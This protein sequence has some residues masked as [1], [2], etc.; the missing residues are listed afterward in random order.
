M[1]FR[2][3][4]LPFMV[5][6]S[7][8]SVPFCVV[9][10]V[11]LCVFVSW[12]YMTAIPKFLKKFSRNIL[13]VLLRLLACSLSFNIWLC[14]II[15]VCFITCGSCVVCICGMHMC[16]CLC[17]WTFILTL[18]LYTCVFA[19]FFALSCSCKIAC[20]LVCLWDGKW[21]CA[22]LSIFLHV[23]VCRH[24]LC[25]FA[26]KCSCRW[27]CVFAPSMKFCVRLCVWVLPSI[28]LCCLACSNSN[29]CCRSEEW[30]EWEVG[31]GA[32]TSWP[33]PEKG[34]WMSVSI[35]GRQAAP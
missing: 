28:A 18:H 24:A 9:L 6:L 17:Q 8:L 19:G 15:V 2:T 35:S 33:P 13:V 5:N 26:C 30:V 31:G 22:S 29:T 11:V 34:S 10:C 14:I 20:T 25:F 16:T 4:F 1:Q 7:A 3:V 27:L 21:M 32:S 12:F 23:H